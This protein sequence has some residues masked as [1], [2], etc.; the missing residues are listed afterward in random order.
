MQPYLESLP[1]YIDGA[2]PWTP[3]N[4]VM[5]LRPDHWSTT[6]KS[7]LEISM[8]YVL[9]TG[10]THSIIQVIFIIHV[11]YMPTFITSPHLFSP[12]NPYPLI[13]PNFMNIVVY[14]IPTPCH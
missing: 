11:N 13:L 2:P 5:E 4:R 9:T 6:L 3:T 1:N 14:F 8:I 7:H 10:Q 12:L